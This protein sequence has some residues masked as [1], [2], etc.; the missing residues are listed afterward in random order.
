[1]APVV[2]IQ[3]TLGAYQI[4]V[5]ISYALLGITTTQA[6]I[7]YIR[8]PDD[9]F[10]L[11]ALVA[12]V[13]LCEVVHAITLGDTLNVLTISDSA[14]W[15][16]RALGPIPKSFPIAT[17]LSGLIG[18]SVQGFFAYRVYALS[19]K[20]V[21]PMS[22]WVMCA[23]RVAMATL[24]SANLLHATVVTFEGRWKWALTTLWAVSTVNDLTVTATL[25][26]ILVSQRDNAYKRTAALVDKL[27]MYTIETGMLTSMSSITALAC[28]ISMPAN[29]I[30]IAI[31]ATNARLISN[32]LLASLNS[33]ASLRAMEQEVTM[34]LS[35]IHSTGTALHSNSAET[36]PKERQ[37]IDSQRIC[38]HC[39]QIPSNGV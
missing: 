37:A 29:F 21:I 3:T 15:S 2:S 13:Y 33:R 30:W 17:F 26:A 14:S 38:C 7:Y 18:G 5:L 8:F 4:G 11:K 23:M 34:P 10:K 16:E 24:I 6:Y 9:S 19:K 31:F 22:C 12:F 35:F 36:T 27:I 32:S 39:G 25:V 28:L 20:L 1:M